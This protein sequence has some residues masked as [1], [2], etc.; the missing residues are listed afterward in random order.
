[1]G[2]R[3]ID[4]KLDGIGSLQNRLD[5]GAADA[6]HEVGRDADWNSRIERDVARKHIGIE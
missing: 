3:D 1:M 6:L 2:L 4:S 5:A